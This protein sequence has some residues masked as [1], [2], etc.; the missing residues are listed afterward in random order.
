MSKLASLVIKYLRIGDTMIVLGQPLHNEEVTVLN[1]KRQ[2]NGNTLVERERPSQDQVKQK[3]IKTA[4]IGTQPC[5]AQHELEQKNKAELNT[6]EKRS[7]R[8]TS[9]PDKFKDFFMDE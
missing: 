7:K 3:A 4:E 2:I 1:K 6:E 8:V 5:V 9:R